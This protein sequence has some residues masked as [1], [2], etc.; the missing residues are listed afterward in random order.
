MVAL[1][2]PSTQ[3]RNVGRIVKERGEYLALQAG[4]DHVDQDFVLDHVYVVPVRTHY[5]KIWPC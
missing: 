3:P 2:S 4:R 1:G 5:G